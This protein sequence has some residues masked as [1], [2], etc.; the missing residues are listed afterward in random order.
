MP[1]YDTVIKEKALAHFQ[2]GGSAAQF[3]KEHD[4]PRTTVIGWWQ[5]WNQDRCAT[6]IGRPQ[7]L[8][9]HRQ[10]QILKGLLCEPTKF[11]R[12][13]DVAAHEQARA[14]GG[15]RLCRQTVRDYL[16]LWGVYP[17]AELKARVE[18][19]LSG[20]A[21]ADERKQEGANVV[22]TTEAW[23]WLPEREAEQWSRCLWRVINRRGFEWFAFTERA[24]RA[25]A[26]KIADLLGAH[27]A[28]TVHTNSRSLRLALRA[29]GRHGGEL[30]FE[31]TDRP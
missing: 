5:R 24:M 18:R 11:L 27:P 28:W 4:A 16:D 2:S 17:N 21:N 7:S 29:R 20:L 31:I 23:E 22:I 25:D 12:L 13:A 19:Y 8:D 9:E 3:A 30:P 1:S 6:R 26:G 15:R 14:P 10:A